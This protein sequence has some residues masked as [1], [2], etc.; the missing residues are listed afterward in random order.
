LCPR[1]FLFGQNDVTNL[2]DLP[3]GRDKELLA[4][5][6]R[7]RIY[8][9]PPWSEFHGIRSRTSSGRA[10]RLEPTLR[11]LRRRI[12]RC[13][14][15]GTSRRRRGGFQNF[16]VTPRGQSNGDL[17]TRRKVFLLDFGWPEC[18]AAALGSRKSS[19]DKTPWNVA[20]WQILL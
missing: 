11:R 9:L 6:R 5:S 10:T 13:R 15:R 8:A 7:I 14:T 4:G 20:Y 1:E 18:A 19:L 12:S 16:R 3:V 2:Q 17:G